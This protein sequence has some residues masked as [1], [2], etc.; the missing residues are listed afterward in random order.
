M[1]T[2]MTTTKRLIAPCLVLAISACS[3]GNQFPSDVQRFLDRR[4]TCDHLRGEIP[5]EPG[6]DQEETIRATNEACRGT[7]N[8]LSGL[9]EK[10]YRDTKVIE[11]LAEFPL[12][13]EAGPRP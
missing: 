7:D 2:D 10:Y 8:E 6:R 11:R 4:A 1:A 3:T 12:R 5:G 9:R 13:I